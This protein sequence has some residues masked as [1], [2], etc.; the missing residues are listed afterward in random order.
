M[1][2]V[3]WVFRSDVAYIN[4]EYGDD[5]V[6]YVAGGERLFSGLFAEADS[7]VL[8]IQYV[9]EIECRDE[10]SDVEDIQ[11]IRRGLRESVLWNLTYDPFGQ[12]EFKLRTKG[13]SCLMECSNYFEFSTVFAKG[14]W[15]AVCGVGYLLR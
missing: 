7:L 10:T 6:Q 5:F 4:Q 9:G 8:I 15:E 3:G 12:D 1:L 13:S 11:D 2:P 14:N